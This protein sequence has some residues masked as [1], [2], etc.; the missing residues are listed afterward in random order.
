MV[1]LNFGSIHETRGFVKGKKGTGA[2][3]GLNVP[4]LHKCKN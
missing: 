1:A 2:D 4:I 3:K